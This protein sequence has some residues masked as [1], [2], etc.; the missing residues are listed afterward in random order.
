MPGDTL[1]KLDTKLNHLPQSL[2]KNVQVLV[3]PSLWI[4]KT[5]VVQIAMRFVTDNKV[6][7]RMNPND[8]E[9]NFSSCDLRFI[10]VVLR[11]MSAVGWTTLK[12]CSTQ[13]K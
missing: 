5:T 4:Q 13:N 6:P 2:G 8:S 11:E 7:P 10:F 9:P 3:S 12:F 1:R